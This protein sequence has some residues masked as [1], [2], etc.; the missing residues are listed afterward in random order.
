MCLHKDKQIRYVII[1]LRLFT[2]M[3]HACVLPDHAKIVY[4]YFLHSIH[5]NN[6][7]L[8]SQYLINTL[9]IILVPF[10]HH[11]KLLSH[12]IQVQILNRVSDTLHYFHNIFMKSKEIH[13]L[14]LEKRSFF[15]IPKTN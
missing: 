14:F 11:I 2:I 13:I 7:L 15:S 8:D 3:L 1:H 6:S 4:T 5:I 10:T 9:K 12:Q